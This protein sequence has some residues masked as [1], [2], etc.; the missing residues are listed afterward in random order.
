MVKWYTR[1]RP[2]QIMVKWYT[3]T[4]PP[5]YQAP[6]NH[7]TSGTLVP[8]P[9]TFFFT[10]VTLVLGPHKPWYK[11]YI[12]TKPP[13]TTVQVAHFY[14]AP[15]NHGK[16]VHSYQAPTNHGTSGTLVPGPTNH[17]TSSTFVSGPPQ[18]QEVSPETTIRSQRCFRNVEVSL[19]IYLYFYD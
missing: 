17:G 15:T 5:S 8:G 10:N 7:G 12:S 13:Q 18:C 9:H 4:R 16:V 2:P 1:T 19:R 3:R 6:T 14:Q 11:L